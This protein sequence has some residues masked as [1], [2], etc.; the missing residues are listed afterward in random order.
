MSKQYQTTEVQ[1]SMSSVLG[2]AVPEQV[3]VAL[4]EIAE[5]ATEG[6]LALAV[7]A[8]LQVMGT[9][10]EESVDALAGPRARTTRTGPPCATATSRA[11]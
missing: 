11:R 1:A 2:L 3:T 9:L 5:S 8:G 7:G 4:A 10:L 6:L